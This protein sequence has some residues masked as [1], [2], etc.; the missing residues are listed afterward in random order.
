MK[1]VLEF[2]YNEK[3]RLGYLVTNSENRKNIILFNSNKDRSTVSYA[4]YLM[5][6][7]E[8]RFLT[9]S[10]QVDH[11]N[12]DKTDDRIENLQI[13]SPIENNRKHRIS[14]GTLGETKIK[15]SCPVCKNIFFL[16]ARQS[17][18]PNP[19]CSRKCGYKKAKLKLK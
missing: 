3:Y 17:H 7:K 6:V 11:I 9:S 16:T 1:I 10:E 12:E 14:K 8:G 4:R 2:P 18:K 5:A 15:F 19:A 13:L